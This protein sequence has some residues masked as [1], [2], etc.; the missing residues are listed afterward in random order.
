MSSEEQA[1]SQARTLLNHLSMAF[2]MYCGMV[3]GNLQR[4]GLDIYPTIY[5]PE[6]GNVIYMGLALV[7]KGEEEAKKMFEVFRKASES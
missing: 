6:K 1:V 7:L 5:Y 4:L 3:R 2:N